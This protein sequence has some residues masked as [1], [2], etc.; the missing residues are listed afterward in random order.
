VSMVF[1]L[2]SVCYDVS[3]DSILL[4]AL[5]ERYMSISEVWIDTMSYDSPYIIN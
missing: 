3:S 2:Y 5:Q 4:L 1:L